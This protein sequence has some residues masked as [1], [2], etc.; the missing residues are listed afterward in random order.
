[1][2]SPTA[3]AVISNEVKTGSVGAV[4]ERWVKITKSDKTALSFAADCD[5]ASVVYY[6]ENPFGQDMAIAD[7][8]VNITTLGT[9]A[10]ADIGLAD[11]AAGT[12]KGVEI[13]D[14]LVNATAGVYKHGL[15]GAI[16]GTVLLPV[17]KTKG[18]A[19]DSF[20][21]ITQNADADA[22]ATRWELLL[23]LIPTV[24][25]GL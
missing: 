1:M 12:N 4:R 14:S 2:S 16:A 19:T 20:I 15:G 25:L 9:D 18:S 11:D 24:D 10:D 21:T 23:K 8:I 17:W 3:V 13:A 7:S 5:A 22:S 6:I